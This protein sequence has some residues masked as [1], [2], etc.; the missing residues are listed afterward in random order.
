MMEA[1]RERA[2]K[3]ILENP[4]SGLMFDSK[5]N[6]KT[7]VMVEDEETGKT[8]P[9]VKAE[10]HYSITDAD[11]NYLHHLTK[12]GKVQDNSDSGDETEEDEGELVS[13]VQSAIEKKPAEQVARMIC[14]WIHS[15][16]VDSTLW[17]RP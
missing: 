15:R 11:G 12:P 6:K 7:L 16:G 4:P 10:D 5:I 3:K 9:G 14:D 2:E 13:E 1:A 17:R 8:F